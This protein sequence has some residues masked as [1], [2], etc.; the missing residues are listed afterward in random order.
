MS[1][2]DRVEER[3]I[4]GAKLEYWKERT[5]RAEEALRIADEM[6]CSNTNIMKA[7]R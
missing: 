4:Q 3:T 5:R 2:W 1:E 7:A 6:A